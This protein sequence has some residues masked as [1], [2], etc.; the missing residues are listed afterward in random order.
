MEQFAYNSRYTTGQCHRICQLIGDFSEKSSTYRSPCPL[1]PDDLPTCVFRQR[2][3]FIGFVYL[4]N[5]PATVPTNTCTCYTNS[6][7]KGHETHARTSTRDAKPRHHIMFCCM[8]N[9]SGFFDTAQSV[10][11]Q[12]E[13]SPQPSRCTILPDCESC[14]TVQS[15]VEIA[16]KP[17]P[18]QPSP[19]ALDYRDDNCCER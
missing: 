1:R 6:L 13:D 3:N 18:C 7:A 17:S 9:L 16:R 2:V 4:D 12:Q 10:E 14:D 11:R 19:L 8:S 5:L 15:V